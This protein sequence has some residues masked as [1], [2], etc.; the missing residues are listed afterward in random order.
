M[1]LKRYLGIQADIQLLVKAGYKHSYA[2][3]IAERAKGRLPTEYNKSNIKGPKW[4]LSI[5]NNGKLNNT[6]FYHSLEELKRNIPELKILKL[7]C[8]NSNVI[9]Y[10]KIIKS[11]YGCLRIRKTRGKNSCKFY[12]QVNDIKD[13]NQFESQTSDPSTNGQYQETGQQSIW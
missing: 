2:K 4:S 9:I 7:A 10:N 12:F 8:F 3:S 1:P 6:Y 13:E 11:K 5:Y